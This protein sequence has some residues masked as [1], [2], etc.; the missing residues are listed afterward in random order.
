MFLMFLSVIHSSRC[1]LW[2]IY[3]YVTRFLSLKFSRSSD[4]L[5]LPKRTKEN[6]NVF[7]YRLR[8]PEL[9]TFN[10]LDAV[11]TFFMLIDTRIT[12][13]DDLA[14]GEIPI[15][16]AA[17]VS[18]KFIGKVNLSVLRKYMMYTQVCFWLIILYVFTS[19]Y[20]HRFLQELGLIYCC[21][22]ICC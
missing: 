15:F 21:Y 1:S 4:M 20:L 9:D 7:I 17:N 13:D 14:S 5:P 6:Y 3:V 12:A 10:F 2:C 11:K 19:I 22:L 16:D 8:E 18:L